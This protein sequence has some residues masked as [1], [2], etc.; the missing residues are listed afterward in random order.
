MRERSRS[1]IYHVIIRGINKQ[2]IFDS[3]DDYMRFIF[4]LR[5]YKSKLNYSIYAYV[6]MDNHVHLLLREG[7]EDISNTMRRIEVSYATWFNWKYERSGHLFQDRFRSKVIE[8]EGHLLSSLRYIHQNPVKAGLV[9][10]AI[11]YPWSSYSEYLGGEH[12]VDTQYVLGLFDDQRELAVEHF[13]D[14]NLSAGE[15]AFIETDAR[16]KSMVDDVV[17]KQF[18]LKFEAELATLQTKETA[19]QKEMLTYLKSLEGVSLRQLSRLTGLT[20]NKIFRA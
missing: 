15:D 17:K 8:S 14:Y 11:S 12:L 13:V 2:A 19:L 9:G 6:L 3:D 20:V 1:G 4:L 5:A 18:H 10:T 7:D 16:R